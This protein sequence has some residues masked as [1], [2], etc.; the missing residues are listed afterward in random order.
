MTLRTLF[1]R[2]KQYRYGKPKALLRKLRPLEARTAW[3]MLKHEIQR[4]VRARLAPI[5]PMVAPIRTG[6]P[7]HWVCG[8]HTITVKFYSDPDYNPY[9]GL[10]KFQRPT[11]HEAEYGV[12]RNA[13]AYLLR[14]HVVS[15]EYDEDQLTRDARRSNSR[16]VARQIAILDRKQTVEFIDDHLTGRVSYTSVMIECE[17]LDLCEH[18]GPYTDDEEGEMNADIED[19][20][21]SVAS[22]ISASRNTP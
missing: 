2:Y 9:E 3:S 14:G 11:G 18:R 17:A 19:V 13:N 21:R 7:W 5:D 15:L 4:E 6:Q 1:E 20:L 16:G 10:C 22:R 12:C 8:A